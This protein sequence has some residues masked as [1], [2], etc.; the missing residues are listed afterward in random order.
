MKIYF[1]KEKTISWSGDI[2]GFLYWVIWRWNIRKFL[3]KP[4]NKI[5]NTHWVVINK[6][7]KKHLF[8]YNKH[9]SNHATTKR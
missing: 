1:D 2:W 7:Y 3:M 6:K 4:L 5:A 8:C 9:R